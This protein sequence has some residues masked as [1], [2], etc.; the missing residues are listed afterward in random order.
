MS[1]INDPGSNIPKLES[2][3]SGLSEGAGAKVLKLCALKPA[4]SQRP[5]M[6]LK[7][8]DV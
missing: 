2:V 5:K 7:A 6:P 1:Y 3:R 4:I 8:R